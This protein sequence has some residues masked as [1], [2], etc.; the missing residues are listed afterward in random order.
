MKIIYKQVKTIMP[1]CPKCKNMLGGNGSVLLPYYCEC[2]EW[3]PKDTWDFKGEYEII[4]S[5]TSNI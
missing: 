4:K 3:K 5:K 2:G 1:H